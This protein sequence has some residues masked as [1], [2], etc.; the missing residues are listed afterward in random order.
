MAISGVLTYAGLGLGELSA[1]DLLFS[2]VV[3]GVILSE[4]TGPFF[5]RNILVRAGEIS[6]R[7]DDALAAPGAQRAHLEAMS[8]EAE[9][10]DADGAGA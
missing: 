6:S 9:A 10:P 5:T 1:V 7:V 2:V 4:L 8:T 3:L